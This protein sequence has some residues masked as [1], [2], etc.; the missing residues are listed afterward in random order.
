MPKIENMEYLSLPGINDLP[1]RIEN[2]TAALIFYPVVFS[3]TL[4]F[5]FMASY[6]S[7]FF[8]LITSSF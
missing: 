1:K 7:S 4:F 8:V 2:V 3:N 5:F 6:S